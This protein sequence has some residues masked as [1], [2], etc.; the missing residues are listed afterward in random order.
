MKDTTVLNLR[1][2]DVLERVSSYP[3]LRY[4]GSKYRLVPHLM[5]A[6]EDVGGLTALDAFSGSG[7]VAYLL[8]NI[9]YAVTTNDFLTFASEVA[10]ATVVNQSETLSAVDIETILGPPADD[11]DFIQKTFRGLYFSLADHQFLDSAWSHIDR[12]DGFKRSLAIS[13]LVLAAAR[14]QP[15]GVFTVT[16][17]RYDDGRRHLHMSLREHFRE[18]IQEYNRTVFE[19]A[20]DSRAFCSDVFD[21]ADENYDVVYLEPPYAPPRDDNC[22]IK[23]YHFLE[24]L[25]VYWQGRKI[26]HHTKTKKLPKRFTPFSYKRTIVDA[27]ER[28]FDKFARSAIVLS[29]SSNAVPDAATIKSLLRNVKDHIELR[30]VDHWYSFGTHEQAER[31]GATEYVFIASD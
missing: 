29:Y 16:D 26:L 7:V 21:L 24:G 5:S 20:Q 31:R 30:A 22:Y 2:E 18:T 28:T 11:R 12:L 14:K 4:M 3:R 23:R 10:H 19:S 9:G 13:A 1:S 17:L 8:K 27:L 15:R 25:S 6:F